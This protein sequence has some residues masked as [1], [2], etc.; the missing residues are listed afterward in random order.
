M[1]VRTVALPLL[2]LA[3]ALVAAP[4]QG[5]SKD[6]SSRKGAE[7][8]E[9]AAAVLEERLLAGVPAPDVERVK[10]LSFTPRFSR[11]FLEAA[12]TKGVAVPKPIP[13]TS[14]AQP[15]SVLPAVTPVEK[16]STRGTPDRP[17]TTKPVK[18]SRGGAAAGKDAAG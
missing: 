4:V 10:G 1:N 6:R 2:V 3:A 15:A 11:A 12:R 5:Q 16:S 18:R 7:G 9:R 8:T 14:P 17:Q 13:S